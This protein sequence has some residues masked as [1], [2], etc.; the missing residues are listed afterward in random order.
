MPIYIGDYLGDTQ[1]LTTEQH[2]AYLLLIFDYWRNGA[3]PDDDAVLQQ[4]T[5][6]N[7][8]AWKKHKATLRA[9]FEVRDGVWTHKRIERERESAVENQGRRSAKA[10]AAADARWNAASITPSDAPSIANGNAPECPPPS[11]SPTKD[12][13]FVPN[14]PAGVSEET[15]QGFLEVRKR[16]RAPV[17]E[18]A[19]GLILKALSK[20]MASP[21]ETIER[22]VMN[23]WTGV[24]PVEA[25]NGRTG[26][27][28]AWL[29]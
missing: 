20:S 16:K 17:T 23:G 2:G 9:L 26:K 27:R 5:R 28:S 4:I 1:R 8:Q 15:W 7:P 6:L 18:R 10:R 25:N 19:Y 13:S 29:G 12:K 11:P 21:E 14:A 3:P 22:S 24:F